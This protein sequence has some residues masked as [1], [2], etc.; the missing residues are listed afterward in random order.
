MK[1][2]LTILLIALA[3]FL[4]GGDTCESRARKDCETIT[5]IAAVCDEHVRR[6]CDAEVQ[7]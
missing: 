7:P 2:K 4:A 3:L 1:R 6:T 5:G